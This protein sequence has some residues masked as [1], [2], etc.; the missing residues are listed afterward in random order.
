MAII[1]NFLSTL[2]ESTKLSPKIAGQLFMYN[3]ATAKFEVIHTKW[4]KNGYISRSVLMLLV[5]TTML[6]RIISINFHPEKDTEAHSKLCLMMIVS[7]TLMAER[8]RIRTLY[9]NE[10]VLF[11]NQIAKLESTLTKGMAVKN[12]L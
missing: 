9:P 6:D 1:A 8:Y 3:E 2:I 5:C 11:F 4:S 10:F 12:I 7:C